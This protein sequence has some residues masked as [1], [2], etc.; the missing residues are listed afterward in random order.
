MVHFKRTVSDIIESSFKELISLGCI[1]S[2]N[3]D[4]MS[5][6]RPEALILLVVTK[7]LSLETVHLVY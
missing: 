7:W 3:S 4:D 2:L 1:N 6:G 5:A